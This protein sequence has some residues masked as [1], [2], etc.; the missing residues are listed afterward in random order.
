MKILLIH[1]PRCPEALAPDHME[2]LA[3]EVLAATIPEHE[4]RI[5]DLRCEAPEALSR[6]LLSFRPCLV[7][8]TV[9]NSIHVRSSLEVLRNIRSILPGA[10]IVVGG[11]HPTLVPRDFQVPQVDAIFI[12]WADRSFPAY[13]RALAKQDE[14]TS[15]PG[16]QR[17]EDGRPL[18]KEAAWH[19]L[20]AHEIP[21]P[22]RE[23]ILHYRNRY[24]D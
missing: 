12:G 22:R 14:V 10:R 11:H 7:G 15:I 19:P 6:D 9:N 4:V 2:P 13:V 23:L 18:E 24:R 16:V 20:E 8:L 3:L 17:L 5:M 21:F 1:P